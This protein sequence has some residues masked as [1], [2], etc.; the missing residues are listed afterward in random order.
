MKDLQKVFAK[1]TLKDAILRT[2]LH[3]KP[4]G[5][6]AEGIIDQGEKLR[7]QS[8]TKDR[9][10]QISKALCT[11]PIFCRLEKGVYSLALLHPK[12]MSKSV[13]HVAQKTP[14]KSTETMLT[15]EHKNLQTQLSKL[16]SRKNELQSHQKRLEDEIQSHKGKIAAE[17]VP[18]EQVALSRLLKYFYFIALSLII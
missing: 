15:K 13:A 10:N 4:K 17:L 12:A 14:L 8:L 1:G 3:V 7:I 16:N 11:D 18:L 6:T 5:L 2:L 9:K